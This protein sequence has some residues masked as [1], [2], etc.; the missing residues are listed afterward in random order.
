MPE[1]KID[2]KIRKEVIANPAIDTI[3]LINSH[4]LSVRPDIFS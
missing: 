4:S 1:L 2:P 3:P